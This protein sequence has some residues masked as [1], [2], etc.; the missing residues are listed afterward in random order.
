MAKR[1]VKVSEE[2]LQALVDNWNKKDA[3]ELAQMLGAGESTI[4][5]W[6]GKLRK[7]MKSNGMSDEQIK[8]IL[9][10]KR[11]VLGNVYD[12]VVKRMLSPD[13]IPTKRRGRKPKEVNQAE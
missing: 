2:K 5:Y 13:Q 4:N 6:A 8:K 7:S 11:K 3:S 9:P 12:I 1:E 10:A